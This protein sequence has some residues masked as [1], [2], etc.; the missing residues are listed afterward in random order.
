MDKKEKELISMHYHMEKTDIKQQELD[1]RLVGM[2][3]N[4]EKSK[5]IR[6]FYFVFIIFLLLTISGLF[7][8]FNSKNKEVSN[9]PNNLEQLEDFKILKSRNDS[10]RVQIQK[11]ESYIF[12]NKKSEDSFSTKNIYASLDKTSFKAQKFCFIKRAY[13]SNNTIFIEVDMIEY[14]EGK[15]AVEKA[16]E[17][18]DAEFD[19]DKN[20]DSLFFLY[21]KHYI[22]NDTTKTII[23]ELD[24]KVKVK[25]DYI[26]QISNGFSLKA[27]QNIIPNHPILRIKLKDGIVYAITEQNLP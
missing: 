26:N 1:D 27:L 21:N 15:E 19:I 7:V 2:A 12:E 4:L 13:E 17:Y 3:E 14:Y 5:K 6:N 16:K 24:E 25:T 20:G 23:L 18:G 10:L 9:I 11:L 22:K 8:Y